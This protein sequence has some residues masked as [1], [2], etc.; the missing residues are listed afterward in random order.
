MVRVMFFLFAMAGLWAVPLTQFVGAAE[1]PGP[2]A[3]DFASSIRPILSDKCFQCH[4]PDE[5]SR[6]A[7]LRLDLEESA[8]EYAIVPGELDESLVWERIVSEDPYEQMPPPDSGKSL[9]PDEIEQLRRWI[10]Q[11][12]AY[13]AHWSLIP[14]RRP[15][16]PPVQDHR[17]VAK[18]DRP[19][20]SGTARAGR[21]VAFP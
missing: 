9:T 6:E 14:P 5:A 3:V 16:L 17:M 12:A 19:V 15:D 4:G 20:H 18:C 11:G 8:K 7:D 21:V 2:E 1:A 10:E 13:E